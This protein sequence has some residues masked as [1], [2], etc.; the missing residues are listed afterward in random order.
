MTSFL[1]SQEAC[2]GR[3]PP[4][5]S[6]W[7]FFN[8]L[9]K[10]VATLPFDFVSPHNIFAVIGHEADLRM[11]GVK[12]SFLKHKC[13]LLDSCCVDIRQG[14]SR[15]LYKADQFNL[16][17]VTTRLKGESQEEKQ[18]ENKTTLCTK[19][20]QKEKKKNQSNGQSRF[21]TKCLGV[22]ILRTHISLPWLLPLS[23][24]LSSPS[25]ENVAFVILLFLSLRLYSFYLVS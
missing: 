3:Q 11:I 7:G 6:I 25:C 2:S 12:K 21:K 18:S 22:S 17:K 13:V 20:W 23:F 15:Y 9:P 5:L 8:C 24:S 10:N 14:A 16:Q 4:P 19:Y 1:S